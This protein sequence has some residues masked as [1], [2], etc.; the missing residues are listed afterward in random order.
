[1]LVSVTSLALMAALAA[2]PAA[3]MPPIPTALVRPAATVHADELALDL[4]LPDFEE[5]AE[6]PCQRCPRSPTST[7]TMS[8]THASN[9]SSAEYKLMGKTVVTYQLVGG[10]EG[11]CPDQEACDP[12]PCKWKF[13]ISAVN[14]SPAGSDPVNIT[15]KWGSTG[16][17]TG[18][19]L[20]PGD[21]A[22]VVDGGERSLAC[23]SDG[24]SKDLQVLVSPKSNP[25]C[26]EL[27]RLTHT[28]KPCAVTTTGVES[29][30][31]SRVLP[32]VDTKQQ[33][34]D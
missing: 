12:A 29:V 30:A 15:I 19:Q 24:A 20:K 25:N 32:L 23:D 34:E 33:H 22:K 6:D 11:V 13:K 1:M 18:F 16:I 31:L 5:E 17:G 4:C 26:V 7:Q 9:C 2:N 28:C 10:D 3:S 8:R 14:N 21:P 27:R